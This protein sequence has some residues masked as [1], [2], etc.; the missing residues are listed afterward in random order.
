MIDTPQ[1]N[2]SLSSE[3]VCMGHTG[4]YGLQ[5]LITR[6]HQKT[7]FLV[8]LQEAYRMAQLLQVDIICSAHARRV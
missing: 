7:P 3:Q 8:A 4:N 2:P 1:P 6:N 5:L